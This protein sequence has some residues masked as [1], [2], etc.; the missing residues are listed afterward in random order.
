M[1]A[2]LRN[3]GQFINLG[4]PASVNEA[5]DIA[6]YTPFMRGQLG[7]VTAITRTAYPNLPRLFQY[8]K[9]SSTDAAGAAVAG[10]LAFWKDYDNFIV[11]LDATDSFDGA[12]SNHVAGIFLGA[13]PDVGKFGYLQVAGIA[14]VWLKAG[15]A[16]AATTAG[17]PL[18]HD[19]GS[20]GNADCI[21]AYDSTT[22]ARTVQVFAKAIEANAGG[23]AKKAILLID[24]VGW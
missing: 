12:G 13:N 11:T 20:D 14:N 1:G 24:R 18:I 16:T 4:D 8:I 22:A 3:N 23:A 19:A 15:P 6:N 5:D 2:D 7:H 17:L 10:K 9:R 21:V